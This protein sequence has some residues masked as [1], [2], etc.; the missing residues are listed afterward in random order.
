LH[1]PSAPLSYRIE[2]E[3]AESAAGDFA[4]I[5]ETTN[6]AHRV[7]A[8][9]YDGRLTGDGRPTRAKNPQKMMEARHFSGSEGILGER[10]NPAL[11]R[12]NLEP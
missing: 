6:E 5:I 2:G 1:P 8:H 4:P 9:G 12:P 3:T 10:Q 11:A 7:R